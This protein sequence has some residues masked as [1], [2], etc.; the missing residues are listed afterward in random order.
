MAA[1]APAPV[2]AAANVQN[3][4]LRS[5]PLQTNLNASIVDMFRKDDWAFHFFK[6][7]AA[8]PGNIL[9]PEKC[10]K[11]DGVHFFGF[12]RGWY[13]DSKE[14]E[15]MISSAPQ[16]LRVH[17]DDICLCPQCREGFDTADYKDETCTCWKVHNMIFKC[18]QKY[19]VCTYDQFEAK[20]GSYREYFKEKMLVR[21][22]INSDANELKKEN[23]LFLQFQNMFKF[24]EM[25]LCT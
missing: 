14:G 7:T 6:Q 18:S 3:T 2:V 1:A 8:Q 4:N 23:C 24:K 5:N 19:D 22:G 21:A 20:L 13:F 9:E 15:S 25:Y 12:V 11:I 10:K 17:E 16:L